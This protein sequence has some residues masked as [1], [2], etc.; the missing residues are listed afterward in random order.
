MS[1]ISLIF[2]LVGLALLAGF[3]WLLTLPGR[4]RI[5]KRLLIKRPVAEVYAKV[6]DFRSWGEWSPW[7][8]HEPDCPVTYSESP[9]ADSVGGSYAWDGKKIG[10]GS[11]THVAMA[12]NRSLTMEL[13]FTRP[14]KSRS[15]IYFEFSETAEGTEISWIMESG[16]PFFFRPLIKMVKQGIGSD[17]ELGLLLLR[18]ALDPS[19]E[20]PVLEFPGETERAETHYL[21]TEWSGD[22]AD[23]GPA[24][25]KAFTQLFQAL[26]AAGIEHDG[27]PFTTYTKMKFTNDSKWFQLRMCVPVVE[28][29]RCEGLK[30]GKIPAGRY[31]Q[32]QLK[33]RYD[34]LGCAWNSVIANARMNGHKV[35][36]G[37]PCLELYE[38][39]PAAVESPAEIVTSIYL[40]LK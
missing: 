18:H 23:I 5:E 26:G 29:T 4:Y 9:A 19:A 28:G 14:F 38:N 1:L 30:A 10:A 34:F 6:K 33:G 7:M 40:P 8:L 11:M 36:F 27:A 24:A 15:D 16:M 22:M 13:V 35:L 39:D 20:V 12:P 25:E 37:K 32:G 2:S 21:C 3:V 17:F 31:F